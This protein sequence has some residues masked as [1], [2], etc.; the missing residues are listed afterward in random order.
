MAEVYELNNGA[1][2]FILP[3]GGE[4]FPQVLTR[5]DDN[6]L[7]RLEQCAKRWPLENSEVLVELKASIDQNPGKAHWLACDTAFFVNLPL[8]TSTYA[9]PGDMRAQGFRKFGV[10]GIHHQWAA[11]QFPAAERIVSVCLNDAPNAAAIVNREAVDTTGGYSLLDGLPGRSTCGSIDPSIIL[12]L[13]EAGYSAE[14]IETALHQESGYQGL[15]GSS[16]P[17]NELL[18]GSDPATSLARE[19]LL[20]ELVKAIGAMLAS[21]GGA[22]RIVIG[23]EGIEENNKFIGSLRSHLAFTGIPVSFLNEER[24]TIVRSIHKKIDIELTN[25]VI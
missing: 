7:T 15:T 11:E 9:L 12:V 14:K 13:A 10:N 20:H 16:V 25:H 6:A 23:S 24:E 2:V 17:I 5:V 22:E 18:S 4:H 19:I 21:L 1:V 8:A 3:R